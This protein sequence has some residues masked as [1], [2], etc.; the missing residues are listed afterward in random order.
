M[1]KL[2][3]VLKEYVSRLGLD[4]LKYLAARLEDRIGADVAEVLDACTSCQDLDKWLASAKSYTELYDMIDTIQE[5]VI[6]ELD[7]RIPELQQQS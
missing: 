1:K 3:T 2:D 7:K 6:R 5:Y 4:S